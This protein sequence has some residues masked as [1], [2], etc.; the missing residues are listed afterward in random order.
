MINYE[1]FLVCIVAILMLSYLLE[2]KVAMLS[3]RSL[4]PELVVVT[5]MYD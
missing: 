1:H 4:S 3:L 5:T 2:L